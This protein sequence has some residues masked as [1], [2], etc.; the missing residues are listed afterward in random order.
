MYD[1]SDAS[2]VDGHDR[3]VSPLA[4]SFVLLG[5]APN[6]FALWCRTGMYLV[7]DGMQVVMWIGTQVSPKFISALFGVGTLDELNHP[8]GELTLPV[9][10]S[11]I[12]IRCRAIVDSIC[13]HPYRYRL[14]RPRYATTRRL[15]VPWQRTYRSLA[16]RIFRAK[17]AGERAFYD[18]LVEDAKRQQASYVDFLCN[19]H[20]HIQCVASRLVAVCLLRS[21]HRVC[22]AQED[23]PEI[24][25]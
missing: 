7:E 15:P 3:T 20:R 14:A 1:A 13:S 11:D 2:A 21:E 23:E 6:R 16:C 4:R 25:N 24:A 8:T 12:N 5:T 19:I 10:E 18:M 17:D 9:L 22:R